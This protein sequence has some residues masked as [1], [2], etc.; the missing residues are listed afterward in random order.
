MKN[1]LNS[2]YLS[3]IYFGTPE[4][5]EATVVFDTGSNWLTV[6]SNMCINCN[7]KAYDVN[8]SLTAIRIQQDPFEQK[9]GSANLTGY[10]WNDTVCLGRQSQ[11]HVPLSVGYGFY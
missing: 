11:E 10:I 3:T 8:S 1:V 5:Q 2:Q 6:T 9:Y 4:S 7:T